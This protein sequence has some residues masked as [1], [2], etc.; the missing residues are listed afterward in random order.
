MLLFHVYIID[1]CY[2]IIFHTYIYIFHTYIYTYIYIYIYIA[3][4]KGQVSISPFEK[5][6]KIS[7]FEHTLI[8]R[9]EAP[10]TT[11]KGFVV[12]LQLEYFSVT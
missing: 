8:S 3:E 2:I 6:F 5:W 11:T 7:L 9:L 12:N 4:A 1:L 10:I